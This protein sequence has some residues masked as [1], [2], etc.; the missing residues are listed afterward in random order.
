MPQL[1]IQHFIDRYPGRNDQPFGDRNDSSQCVVR[2]S[3]LVHDTKSF[4]FRFRSAR[5]YTGCNDYDA[6]VTH[7]EAIMLIS[8]FHI[9][10]ADLYG[11]GFPGRKSEK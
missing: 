5:M 8:T 10:R 7:F 3:R 11:Y 6:I 1:Y 4:F 2:N 9:F